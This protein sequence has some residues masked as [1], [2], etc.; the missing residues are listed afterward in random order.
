MSEEAPPLKLAGGLDVA[1]IARVYA[2][3]GRVHIR[4]ILSEPAA[5]RIYRCLLQ[6]IPWQ[7][8][9]NDGDRSISRDGASFDALSEADR[10]LV[11]QSVHAGAARGFQYIFNNFSLSDLSE[12]R[13]FR[14]LYVMRV[15]EFLNAPPFL[16]FVRKITGVPS[17]ALVDAQATL[18]RPGHFLTRHD[19]T[20]HGK[21][22]VA[23]YVLNFTP[24]W[25]A[26]W[27][28]IL[29]FI[30]RDGHVAEGYTPVFNALNLFKVPQPHVVSLVA[31]YAQ[32]GR[33]SIT[34]WLREAGP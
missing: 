24:R 20:A 3:V 12:H 31:P 4:P 21:K 13:E 11:M 25:Q 23:A 16:E 15:L 19:D 33:Y 30:D 14:E 5:E 28:G 8:Q 34:G 32:A 22:R 18:Y 26:D 9:L 27:G 6:E 1:A 29:Q 10:A 2:S 17:I 7:V